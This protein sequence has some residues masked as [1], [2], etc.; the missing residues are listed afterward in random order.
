MLL[1]RMLCYEFGN[2]IASKSDSS[3]NDPKLLTEF[4]ALTKTRNKW[5]K[6]QLRLQSNGAIQLVT[7]L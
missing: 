3:S 5:D 2:I 4:K 1:G 7:Q 6:N